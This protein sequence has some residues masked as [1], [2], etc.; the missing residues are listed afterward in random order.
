MNQ[1]CVLAVIFWTELF[2]PAA[3]VEALCFGVD[4]LS[5]WMLWGSACICSHLYLLNEWRYFNEKSHN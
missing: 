4:R 3:M 2:M 1:I 5:T